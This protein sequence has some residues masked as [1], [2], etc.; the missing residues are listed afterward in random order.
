MKMNRNSYIRHLSMFLLAVVL[1]GCNVHEWPE[2]ADEKYPFTLTMNFDTELPLHKVVY[3]TRGAEDDEAGSRATVPTHDIRYIVNIYKVRDEN[4][5]SR[6]VWRR[7]EFTRSYTTDL[8]YTVTLDLP[9]GNYRF[10]VWAD[11]VD[12]NSQNDKYYDTNDFVEIFLKEEN[13]HPGNTEYRDAFKGTAYGVVVDPDIYKYEHGVN[14]NQNAVADMQRPMGRYE[15]IATDV[16]EF[17]TRAFETRGE[18]SSDGPVWDGMTA[19]E[20]V[21]AIQLDQYNVVFSYN[22]FMPSSYNLYTDKTSDSLTGVKYNGKLELNDEGMRMGFDYI[23]TDSETTMNVNMEVY[24]ADGDVVSSVSGVEVPI[25][26]SKNT[27]VKGEFLTVTSG[28]GV[29][30]NPDFEGDFDIEIR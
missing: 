30:I 17:L 1:M 14:P 16:E 3:Y 7:L 13:G 15:F 29:T 4:D 22:A 9:A 10:R 18:V 27:V 25:V 28:G 20:I 11:Y 23:L 8:D 24:N 19:E 21:Q 6:D 12:I 2:H 5:A 26:R